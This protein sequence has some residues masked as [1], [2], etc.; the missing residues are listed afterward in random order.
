MSLVNTH[1][2]EIV[3][4][5]EP[6]SLVG[7][8]EQCESIEAWAE[9]CQSVP[10]LR[11]ASN[12][13]AAIDE[14][15][16]RTS[17]EG[18]ARVAAAMRRLQVRIGELEGEAEVGRNQHSEGSFA[19]DPSPLTKQQR[20]QFRQ[21]AENKDV[22]EDVI[23][24][25]TDEH[26]ASQRR[27]MDAIGKHLDRVEHYARGQSNGTSRPAQQA[28]RPRRADTTKAVALALHKLAEAAEQFAA[29]DPGR[30][31]DYADEVPVW[32]GN[33]AESLKAI[34]AFN[35]ALKETSK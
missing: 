17:T 29:I 3:Q 8:S 34:H 16:T 15:L 26:P 35:E 12:K 32:S 4:Y 6:T 24:N 14:Y 23:A 21:M 9:T 27:V 11:D 2:G 31:A 33:L 7:V 1:T 30:L 22:V 13:L 5:R 20:H 25:S 18:R 19:N 10:E 28:P